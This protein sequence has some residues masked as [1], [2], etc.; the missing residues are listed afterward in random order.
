MSAITVIAPRPVDHHKTSVARLVEW[1]P[2][3]A[4][5]SLV[6]R[7]TITFPGGWTVNSI[8]I[9]RR[10]DGTLSVGAP[11]TPVLASDGTHARDEN[12]KK[13]YL[14]IITF[15]NKEARQRWEAIVLAVLADAGIGAS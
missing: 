14:P 3:D 8:P 13:R 1:R 6:G 12:G 7:C 5:P 15:E 10:K 2:V 11:S 9:F 4:N